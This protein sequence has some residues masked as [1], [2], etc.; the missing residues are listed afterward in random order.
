MAET[1]CLRKI[2]RRA[3]SVTISFSDRTHKAD[4]CAYLFHSIKNRRI[5][6]CGQKGHDAGGQITE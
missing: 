5:I 2:A 4:L 1:H 6:Y 3:S